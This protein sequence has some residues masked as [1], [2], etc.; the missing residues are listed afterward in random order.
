MSC[1]KGIQKVTNTVGSR[2][3]CTTTSLNDSGAFVL[4]YHYRNMSYGFVNTGVLYEMSGIM[5]KV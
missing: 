4:F 2:S 1:C 5:L 3:N